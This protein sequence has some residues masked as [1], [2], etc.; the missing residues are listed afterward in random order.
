MLLKPGLIN[1]CSNFDINKKL[2]IYTKNN[3]LKNL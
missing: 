3:P 2:P 1:V